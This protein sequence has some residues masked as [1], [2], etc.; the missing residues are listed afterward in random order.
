MWL[1]E[2][3]FA[4]VVVDSF[5]VLQNPTS[6]RISE[7]MRLVDLQQVQMKSDCFPTKYSFLD[8][9]SPTFDNEVT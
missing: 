1:N 3:I 5:F 4:S 2:F 7:R 6:E 9:A 8:A